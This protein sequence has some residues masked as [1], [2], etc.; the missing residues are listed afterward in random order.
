M[1]ENLARLCGEG[2]YITMSF[3]EF[4]NPQ[5]NVEE[6]DKSDEKTG[7]EIADEVLNKLMYKGGSE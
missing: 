1:T 6:V 2:R 5:S 3:N 7:D 4:I